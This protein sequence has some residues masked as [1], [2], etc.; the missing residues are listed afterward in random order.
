MPKRKS[1]TADFKL[2]VIKFAKDHGNR[3]AGREYSCNEK[4]VRDWRLEEEELKKMNPR[5][6]ARRGRKARWPNLEENLANWVRSQRDSNR[7]VSTVA[8]KLKARIIATEMNIADFS[9]G[10]VN[11]IYKFMKRNNLTV[12]ARTTVGQKLPDD[13]ENKLAVF[14]TFVLKEKTELKLSDEDIINMDEVPM[15]FDIP[16]SRSVAEKGVKTVAIDTTGHE[17]TNFTVVL[18]C[19]AAGGKL[20]PMVIFKRVTMPRETLP[21]GVVVVCNKK[22]WMNTEVMQTWTDKCF[23]TRRGGFFKKKSLLIFD[24]MAAHKETTVQKHI[25]S[26]GAHI[27][28]IPG[29]LTCKLQPLDVAVNHPFK[30]F[31]REEW[32]RWMTS[33]KHTFTPAG[34]QRRATYVEVCNWVIRA[35]DKVKSTTIVNG[36]RKCGIIPEPAA[37]V[38]SSDDDSAE[39][40]T[41]DANEEQLAAAME[42]FCEASDFDS[43]FDGFDASSDDDDNV[44]E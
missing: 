12:R 24:A 43:S 30:T 19:T 28:V 11:W 14:H 20:K 22:G 16:A 36:F 33:G 42:V 29:G 37:D 8:I 18:A 17:R 32:D 26:A 2:D 40:D 34:R 10:S 15:S 3:A 27:A 7:A 5:K 38:S 9:G 4:N 23:R 44:D 31:V 35:W 6:R 21:A 13:W 1:Y 25:N 39:S 41:T